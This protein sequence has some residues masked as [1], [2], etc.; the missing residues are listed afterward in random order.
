MAWYLLGDWDEFTSTC[1]Q[2]TELEE[3]GVAQAIQ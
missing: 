2:L 3:I 1:D